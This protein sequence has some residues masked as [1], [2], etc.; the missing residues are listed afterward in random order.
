MK[1]ALS[2]AI[3]AKNDRLADLRDVLLGKAEPTF[4][5]DTLDKNQFNALTEG[6]NAAQK[7]SVK[8]ALSASDAA[9]IHGPP[10]T[11]KTTT[12]TALITAA[13]VQKEKVLA[14]AP[15]NLAVDNIA[16]RLLANGLNIVRIG[17]PIRIL[18]SLH[19]VT[20]DA[21]VEKNG[22]YQLAKKLRRDATGLQADAGRWKR[23][24]PEKGEKAAMRREAREMLDE[25]RKLESMAVE[26]VLN[27]AQVI[28]STLT[29][30]DSA[31]FGQRQFDLCVI[32][33]AGQATE[34]AA[35]IP[36]V[37]SNRVVLAG[38]HQQLP[39]TILSNEARRAGFGTSLQ[40]RMVQ[41]DSGETSL[42]S[43]PF[44]KR[45]DVQYRMHRDIMGFSSAEFYENTLLADRSVAE[46][47][48]SDLDGVEKTD[49]T[50]TPVTMIDT[51]G[52][53]YDEEWDKGTR[54]RKNEQEAEL[55][56]QKAKALIEAGLPAADIAI[57]TPYSAQVSLF[58]D[59]LAAEGLNDVDLGSVD[60][61][62]G[63]EKE[64]VI[65]SLVRSNP[66]GE[67]GFLAEQRR[68][69]VALTRARRKLIIIG[70][71]ATITA[72][73]FFG[74]MLSWVENV[75]GYKSVWEEM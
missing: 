45:L 41:M 14:C 71:S 6:L 19:A 7:I 8:H 57:I 60:G 73:E 28:L 53:S 15:S 47:L 12:V 31:I 10:G 48:L 52:A 17:H 68:M 75:G 24:K 40:E 61:F 20:L 64:A 23:A 2:R 13:V 5:R 42:L 38:D 56:I 49:L 51:A 27:G 65:I 59:R 32:D 63:R 35:W 55:A 69:N 18:E 22:D 67:I 39:P 62:Q 21:L 3:S 54:S 26:Q 74:R 34:P 46:H 25:A 9:I 66:D 4:Y 50:S 44:A 11:G 43:K 37:R 33:E 70:D 29:G 58:R 72:D 36:L 1:R 16:E 30:I